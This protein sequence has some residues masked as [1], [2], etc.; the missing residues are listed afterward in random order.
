MAH[1]GDLKLVQHGRSM[2]QAVSHEAREGSRARRGRVSNSY[3]GGI[4]TLS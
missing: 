2:E 1:V 4:W 3:K